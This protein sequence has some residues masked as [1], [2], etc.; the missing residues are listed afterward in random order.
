MKIHSIK[1]FYFNEVDLLPKLMWNVGNIR[2]WNHQI[3]VTVEW[4][5][6]EWNGWVTWLW[7]GAQQSHFH[8]AEAGDKINFRAQFLNNLF[9]LGNFVF[10]PNDSIFPLTIF[11]D[12][13]TFWWNPLTPALLAIT[14]HLL[15]LER[16]SNPLRQ[17]C[18]TQKARRAKLININSPR[19]AKSLFR[20]SV[21]EIMK[22][23][24]I[25][26]SRAFATFSATEFSGAA[27]R[28]LA[29]RMWPAG[30]MLCRPALWIQ[31]VF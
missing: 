13:P 20:H 25:I 10:V 27:R 24:V 1:V 17:A 5:A 6:I 19:A 28:D 3:F 22:G 14:R 2:S 23:Q 21:K 11:S 9:S 8:Q 12:R 26:R 7:A 29:G 4:S 18:T 31:Q 15:Q 16:C 30:R